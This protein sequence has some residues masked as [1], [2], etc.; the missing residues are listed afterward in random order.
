MGI[1]YGK[2]NIYIHTFDKTW[3]IKNLQNILSIEPN[4]RIFPREKKE[5]VN[6]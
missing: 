3:K 5:F 1:F 4:K 6:S 2:I